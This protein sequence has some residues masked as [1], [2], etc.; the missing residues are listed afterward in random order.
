VD[1]ALVFPATI[2]SPA[3]PNPW[4]GYTLGVAGPVIWKAGFFARITCARGLDLRSPMILIIA[5]VSYPSLTGLIRPGLEAW[6][7]GGLKM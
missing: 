6:R 7:L 4:G 5:V 1:Q 3:R 2:H